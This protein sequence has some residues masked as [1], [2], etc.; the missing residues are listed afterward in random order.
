MPAFLRCGILQIGDKRVFQAVHAT[1]ACQGGG[2]VGDQHPACVHQRDAVAALGLVHE[3]GGDEDCHPVAARQLH[4]DP[5]EGVARHGIDTRGGLIENQHLGLVDRGHRQRQALPQPDGQPPR[6]AVHHG[7]QI[8]AFQHFVHPPRNPGGGRPEQPGMQLQVLPHRQLRVKGEELGHI[9][10]AAAGGKVVWVHF[11]PEQPGMAFAGRQQ[12]GQH[13]HRGGL[14]AAVGAEKTEYLPPRDTQ[15]HMIDRGEIAEALGQIP[16]LDRG[17]AIVLRPRWNRHRPITPAFLFRQQ[18]D[19]GGLQRIRPRAL[20]QGFGCVVGQ[21]T[22]IVHGRQPVETCRLL[23]IGGGHQHTHAGAGTADAGDQIPELA[24]REGIDAGGRLIEDEQVRIMDQGTAQSELL[25]HATGELAGGP[26][27]KGPEPGG[28]GQRLDAPRPLAG[29]LPEQPPEEF[30]ILGH[31]KRWIEVPPE[32][33]GHVGDSWADRLAM[34]GIRHRTAKHLHLPGLYRPGARNQRHQARFAHAVR[35]DQAGH[36]AR[37]NIEADP[38][39]R[40]HLAVA[41]G[42]IPQAGNRR[43]CTFV[44][45][46]LCM[47]IPAH[48]GSLVCSSGGQSTRGSSRT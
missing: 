42:H 18:P 8:E 46:D 2:R 44:I 11:L 32:T 7:G 29:I 24:S 45:L 28:P 14:A 12:P 19:E 43:D 9:A 35:A 17:I 23:H 25:L 37:R 10:D 6:Q 4:Q 26:S 5:P 22:A 31:R 40:A 15:V 39:E 20:Q 3:V 1:F 47:Y 13:R 34:A 48:C 41:Q 16:G 21:H 36:A 27:K 30:Q 38:V 33:L